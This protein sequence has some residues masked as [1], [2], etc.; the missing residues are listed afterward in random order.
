MK[1]K[2]YTIPVN[3]VFAVDC[4]CPLCVLEK[5]LEDEAV[6]YFLG[7]SL[8]EPDAR[9]ETNEKGFCRHHF[10]KLFNRRENMLGL[11]LVLDTHLVQQTEM[12]NKL[13][14]KSLEGLQKDASASMVKNLSGKLSSRQ[15][16]TGR[17]ASALSDHLSR[18]EKACCV[19]EKVNHTMDR[20]VDV[21]LYLWLRNRSF[22]SV[23]PI[24][25]AFACTISIC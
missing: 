14:Q 10:E 23:S 25:G 15:T 13:Y 1:E 19:C 22:S 6:E 7:P 20:Y 17:F 2:I 11:G 4:E 16:E 8:M 24:P 12:L 3:E 5:K 9:I 21:V 18:L